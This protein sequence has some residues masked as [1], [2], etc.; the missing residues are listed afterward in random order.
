MGWVPSTIIYFGGSQIV[1]HRATG[2]SKRFAREPQKQFITTNNIT[3]RNCLTE[4]DTTF[5]RV[6]KRALIVG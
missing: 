1:A 3:A 4:S 2:A 6:L 5:L